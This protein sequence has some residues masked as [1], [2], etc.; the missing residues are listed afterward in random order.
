MSLAMIL[1]AALFWK[2]VLAQVRCGW[3][4]FLALARSALSKPGVLE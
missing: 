4:R 3:R 2:L 1:G